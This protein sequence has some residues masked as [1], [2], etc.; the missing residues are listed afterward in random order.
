[1]NWTSARAC[2]RSGVMVFVV[3]AAALSCSKSSGPAQTNVRVATFRD[4]G[5]PIACLASCDDGDPCTVDTCDENSG[6]CHSEVAPDGTAC[7]DG[8]PCSLGDTCKAGV[9]FAGRAKDCTTPPDDCHEPGFCKEG[10]CSYP[11]SVDYKQCDDK[12]LCT[13]GDYCLKG[14]CIA[15]PRQC[16]APAVCDTKDGLCKDN[17]VVAFTSPLWAVALD[18]NI[19][20]QNAFGFFLAPSGS[21]LL[22]GGFTDSI[23]LGDGVRTSLGVHDAFVARF[24]PQDG[25]LVWLRTYGDR[26]EQAGA[27]VAANARGTVAAAG[28]FLGTMQPG[29]D[30]L[31][32]NLAVPMLYVAAHDE[33]DGTV[34]W[35]K[36]FQLFAGTFGI[37]SPG[38][39]M[40]SDQAGD[41][42][43]CGKADKAA[44]D[45]TSN[46]VALG[47][48]DLIVAKL[49]STSGDVKWGRQIGS[50]G[51]D[52][53]DNVVV[54]GSGNIYL[55]GHY[56]RGGTLDF[57]GDHILPACP[58]VEV[59][60]FI[61]KLDGSGT[62]LWANFITPS[63][64][65]SKVTPNNIATD[66]KS[67]WIGGDIVIGAIFDGISVSAAEK[68]SATAAPTA[69]LAG[70]SAEK[71]SVLWPP[72][73]W[74]RNSSIRGIS[75]ASAG[76]LL[77]A[78]DYGQE[79]AFDTG[80]LQ[81]IKEGGSRQSFVAELN[82]EGK[83]LAAQGYAGLAMG[84]SSVLA[85]SADLSPS[86]MPANASYVYGNY[87]G[88]LD[89]GPQVSP[90]VKMSLGTSATRLFL[91][92]FAP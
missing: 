65:Q 92:K 59:G 74:G 51:N 70:Y 44:T 31:V 77:V 4:G 37:M 18:G 81:N 55:T 58:G 88:D 24:A 25:K 50:A 10:A 68:G 8:D 33:K 42:V 76:H 45:L 15:S 21:L 39:H 30:P 1:M 35:A 85:I 23:D 19:D 89:L 80:T 86:G 13:T 11:L 53:C 26:Y 49:D 72:H 60:G 16:S 46:A 22:T 17:G 32:N 78:G 41:F 56:G 20:A 57:G 73:A 2:K 61:A 43:I 47:G 6:L 9:C 82:P 28:V 27:V 67:V 29:T 40:V 87:S 38:I 75:L 63:T 71:G 36:A 90:V 79:M 52:S 48:Y 64:L 66:A 7:E 91:A 54:D 14:A 34:Q 3:M 62:T 12:M 5:Y 83:A 84:Q 69:F